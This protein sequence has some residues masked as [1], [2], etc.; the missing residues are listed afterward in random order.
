MLSRFYQYSYKCIRYFYIIYLLIYVHPTLCDNIIKYIRVQLS[1][2]EHFN[3]A[4]THAALY[5]EHFACVTCVFLACTHWM[6]LGCGWFVPW[7]LHLHAEILNQVKTT[8][9]CC[10]SLLLKATMY[11]AGIILYAI[12][13][14]LASLF[15]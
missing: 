9:H 15:M 3:C 12:Y 8:L 11:K 2:V 5:L 7:V 10:K 4:C 6:L 14:L 1:N 13:V